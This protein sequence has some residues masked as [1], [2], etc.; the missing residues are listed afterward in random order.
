MQAHAGRPGRG[1]WLALAALIVAVLLIYAPATQAMAGTM[2]YQTRARGAAILAR[3]GQPS[4]PNVL[5]DGLMLA[6]T[7]LVPGVS[8]IAAEVIVTLL[9]Q[10][11]SAAILFL[12]LDHNGRAQR[13]APLRPFWTALA[14]LGVMLAGPVTLFSLPSRNLYLGYLT[15]SPLHNPTY[16]LMKPLALGAFLVAGRALAPTPPRRWRGIAAAALVILGTLAKPSYTLCLLP[17]LALIAAI[18]VWKRQPLDWPLLIGGFAL[19]GLLVLGCE[20]LLTYTGAAPRSPLI[21]APLA[22]IG[23]YETGGIPTLLAKLAMSLL[24]PVT[25]GVACREEAARDVSLRLA[26]SVFLFGAL[27]S[28]LLAESRYPHHMNWVWSG[29]SALFVLYIASMRCL[30]QRIRQDS[31]AL[32]DLSQGSGVAL[33]VFAFHLVSGLIF[34]AVHLSGWTWFAW[35]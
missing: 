15:P 9:A 34:Y 23:F 14:A 29:D 32:H 35:W 2:D 31:L 17:G 10:V 24:F 30:L 33:G 22:A 6:I 12:C 1:Y 11:A 18:G 27:Y 8:L 25:V 4:L 13:T 7:G 20:Y 16:T 3:T 21:V 19:P 26:W 5:L 28:Y